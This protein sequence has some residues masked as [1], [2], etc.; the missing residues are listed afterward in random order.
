M[1]GKRNDTH[2]NPYL[3]DVCGE[4]FADLD[5][6]I[7]HKEGYENNDF[8]LCNKWKSLFTTENHLNDH[9]DNH[10]YHVQR[11]SEALTDACSDSTILDCGTSKQSDVEIEKQKIKPSSSVD[12]DCTTNNSC[13][14]DQCR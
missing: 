3:C 13:P 12:R 4:E 6:F 10:K 7:L 5:S 11:A 14:S 2:R 9:L 8:F 1:S